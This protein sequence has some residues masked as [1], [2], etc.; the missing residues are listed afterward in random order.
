M[1]FTINLGWHSDASRLA[2]PKLLD[3]SAF[4]HAAD[5][6]ITHGL[7]LNL[8]QPYSIPGTTHE[9]GDLGHESQW[10]YIMNRLIHCFK[11]CGYSYY[12][13]PGLGDTYHNQ[14]HVH[15][16]IGYTPKRKREVGNAK[17]SKL[18][19]LIRKAFCLPNAQQCRHALKIRSVKYNSMLKYMEQNIKELL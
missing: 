15:V 8:P 13:V 3:P 17:L 7:T 11:Q 16:V 5:H 9:L 18:K 1:P 12:A 6:D 4:K 10:N 2:M 19:N 14:I